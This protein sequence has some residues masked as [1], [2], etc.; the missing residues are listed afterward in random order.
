M[1]LVCLSDIHGKISGTDKVLKD[2]ANPDLVPDLV[3]VAGDITQRGDYGDAES[4]ISVFLDAEYK[5]LAVPGNMDTPGV[6]EFLNDKGINI[7]GKSLIIDKGTFTV[8]F[9]GLGGSS[10]TPFGTPFEL[11]EPEM[12]HYLEAAYSNIKNADKIV[13]I[14]HAPPKN[15]FLDRGFAGMHGGSQAVRDFLEKN[16]VDLCICGHIHESGGEEIINGCRCVNVSAFKN[17]NYCI[18]DILSDSINIKRRKI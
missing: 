8:G 13:L 2:A 14:S 18:T 10:R 12:K 3:V 6:M 7:H 4:I 11:T 15:S 16:K 9:L 1:R 5:V 17:G